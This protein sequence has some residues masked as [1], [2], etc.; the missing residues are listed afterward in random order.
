VG[1]DL[2]LKVLFVV[3][4]SP[5]RIRTRPYNL[6]RAL[7][8]QGH[9]ISLVTLCAC[10]SEMDE[11]RTLSRDLD[12]LV[13]ERIR[14]SRSI[15][16]C[17]KTL[18]SRKPLQAYYSWSPSLARR[19]VGLVERTRFDAIHVEHL[20]GV[21]YGLL[22][23]KATAP[24]RAK[25]PALVWDSV[26]CI[27]SLFH[28]AA[29]ESLTTRSRLAA[30]LDLRRT[31][32]YEGWLATCFDRVLVTS[33]NDRAELA[34]LALSWRRRGGASPTDSTEERIL[35]VPNG[36]DL[37]YFSPGT[38]SRDPLTLLISGKMS[39]HA[40]VTAVVRFVQ[41]VMPRVWAELPDVRLS[42]VGKDPPFQV[43]KLGSAENNGSAKGDGGASRVQVT[44]TVDDIRPFL[45]RATV[46]V[47]P[48]YYGAGIQN[49]VLE[50]LASGLPVVAT[51]AAVS[52]LDVRPGQDLLV[53]RD[54]DELAISIVSLLRNPELR[55]Q[56]GRA[57]RLLVERQHQ[58]RTVAE[59]LTRI[60]R[61][62]NA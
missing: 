44:G 4:Y 39:Y 8:G 30:R 53:A 28:Q 47:A 61:E 17:L 19:A 24:L 56:L 15:W 21:R 16:N 55:R 7:A 37:D 50:A 2:P 27:S 49:K 5:T 20:R 31:E 12:L 60:Y 42:I 45:R 14:F 23:K 43:R 41:E 58:W 29:R 25:R 57:G 51:P 18:P 54:A 38:E 32:Y 40:N 26:D 34:R 9:H 52:A 6:I 13:A 59:N 62:A 35:V 48:I 46:A 3:P 11:V 33:E 22:L 1:S 10:D 36:V